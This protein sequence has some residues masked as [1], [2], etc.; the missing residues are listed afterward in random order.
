MGKKL[1]FLSST[2]AKKMNYFYL[3][4]VLYCLDI[5]ELAFCQNTSR[6]DLLPSPF[7]QG[8][9]FFVALSMV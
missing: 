3:V 9:S 6:F 5:I 7:M 1:Y 4:L 8:F 2:Q